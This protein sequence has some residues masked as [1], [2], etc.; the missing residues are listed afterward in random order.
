[1]T[2]SDLANY[3]QPCQRS[4]N[5]EFQS[6]FSVSKIGQN[7]PKK[8]SVRNIRLRDQLTLMNILENFD[9]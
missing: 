8:N 3:E 1:M 2:S 7:F 9:F 5:S 4:Q 6:Q